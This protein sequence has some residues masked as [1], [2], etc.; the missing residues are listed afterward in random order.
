LRGTINAGS[1]AIM[2]IGRDGKMVFRSATLL[3]TGTAFVDGERL[4]QQSESFVTDR[5]DCGPVYRRD[6][7]GDE[8][9]YAHVNGAIL[10]YF[11]PVD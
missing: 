7:E 9:A 5:P 3:Y 8:P 1:P 4:C 6:A 2:Q 10:F 11:S